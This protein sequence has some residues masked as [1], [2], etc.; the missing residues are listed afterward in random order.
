MDER[1]GRL[2]ELLSVGEAGPP[3]PEHLLRLAVAAVPN[4]ER[5][6]LTAGGGDQPFQTLACSDAV[7]ARLDQL[8]F[9]AGTGPVLDGFDRTDV[10]HVPDLS[11]DRRWPAFA[12]SALT[13]GVH[14]VLV[15]RMKVDPA[16]RAALTFY[17]GR[18]EAFSAV[19]L[20]IAVVFGSFLGETLR[21]RRQEE[22]AANLAAALESNRQIGTAI[23]ILMARELLTADQAFDRL[24]EASQRG[25]RKVRDVADEVVRTGALP[26]VDRG[27]Q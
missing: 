20:E 16:R 14:A 8:Q 11:V 27:S 2:A 21:R 12:G 13:A 25:H 9:A 26:L 19:D 5:A 24:R 1:L 6:C 23:G 10:V 18:P 17:A 7:A 22:H 15:V 4:G 3:A